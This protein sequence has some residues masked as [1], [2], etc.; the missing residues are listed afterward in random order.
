MQA[1]QASIYV[2]VEESSAQ[3]PHLRS[4]TTIVVRLLVEN[5]VSVP[6]EAATDACQ[7]PKPRYDVETADDE[8]QLAVEFLGVS[9]ERCIIQS[10]LE[11]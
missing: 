8:K 10:R 11:L 5:P 3:L 9:L 7:L 6:V 4:N 1:G 2:K